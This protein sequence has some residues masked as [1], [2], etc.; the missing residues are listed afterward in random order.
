LQFGPGLV[1]FRTELTHLL[2]II[3]DE[4]LALKLQ[5]EIELE[6]SK[7]DEADYPL[8]VKEY[9]ET[10]QFEVPSLFCSA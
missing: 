8:S 7:E 5:T 2:V 3:V 4:E 10:G 1:T 9:L 6:K